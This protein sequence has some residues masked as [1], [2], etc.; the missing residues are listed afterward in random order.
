MHVPADKRLVYSPGLA[1]VRVVG[2]FTYTVRARTDSSGKTPRVQ[3]DFP[4][5]FIIL[6]FFPV[7]NTVRFHDMSLGREPRLS[8]F[9]VR[10]DFEKS[11]FLTVDRTD[12][13]SGASNVP[14][15]KVNLRSFDGELRL[16]NLLLDNLKPQVGM[17]FEWAYDLPP[18]DP[19]GAPVFMDIRMDMIALPLAE[20]IARAQTSPV[21]DG[22]A[23]ELVA[24]ARAGGA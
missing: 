19:A 24:R 7:V 9:L 2:N 12:E 13:S 16:F 22:L 8:D 15:G 10:F 3:F 23:R 6:A 5:P 17:E 18:L 14:S 21:T 4:C 11:Q 1:E 20:W